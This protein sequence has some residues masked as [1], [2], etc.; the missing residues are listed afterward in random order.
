MSWSKKINLFFLF[1]LTGLFSLGQLQRVELFTW[2]AFYVH[3]VIIFI[4]ITFNLPIKKIK[5]CYFDNEERESVFKFFRNYK[6]EIILFAWII[7]GLIVNLLFASLNWQL[8]FYVFRFSAYSLLFFLIYRQKLISK[9]I[10]KFAFLYAG[11]MILFL[12]L[13][14]YIFLPDMRFLKILSWDDH[15]YR[16]ISTQFDPNYAGLILVITYVNLLNSQ[17][18]KLKLT[19]FFFLILGLALTFSRAS[20][21]VFVIINLI[22]FFK[23]KFNYKFMLA[24]LLLIFFIWLIPKPGGEGVNLSRIS[25]LNARVLNERAVAADLDSWQLILGKG[26]FN[27]PQLK[28]HA[29]LPNNIL[30]LIVNYLGLGGLVLSS[31]LLFKHLPFCYRKNFIFFL[32]FLAVLIHSQFNNSFFQPFVFLLMLGGI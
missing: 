16:L 9:K 1:L 27:I 10:I 23:H 18:K 19:L 3:D 31:L 4:W 17:F 8:I 5:K 13:L 21:L 14:Q 25:S 26:L 29:V 22:L 28:S 20:Y 6:L 11:L 2:P 12:G 24:V 15:Y 30:L 32:I 7:L